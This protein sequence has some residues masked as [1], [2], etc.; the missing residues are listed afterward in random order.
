MNSAELLRM[1]AQAADLTPQGALKRK[2][3]SAYA[4]AYAP[5]I[6]PLTG[7]K[8]HPNASI[9]VQQTHSPVILDQPAT[10][11]A[12]NKRQRRLAKQQALQQRQQ[13]Q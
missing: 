5:H 4:K 13:R 1:A 7:I 8:N 9:T 6:D 2:V 11:A 10:I 3:Q 12:R